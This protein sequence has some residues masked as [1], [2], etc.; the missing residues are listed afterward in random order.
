MNRRE[1]DAETYDRI[2][3]VQVAWAKPVLERLPLRGDETV[4]DAGCGSGRVTR[5]LLERLP[6]GRVIAVDADES[7]LAHAREARAGERAT[8]LAADLADLEL[9]HSVDAVFSNAVFHWVPDHDRLFQ[10]MHAALR[11]GGQLIAQCGG[12]GNLEDFLSLVDVVAAE[13]PYS[14]YLQNFRRIWCFAGA[15]ETEGRLRRAGFR[16]A[17]AWLEPSEVVREDPAEFLRTVV[18]GVHLP[19]L[20]EELRDPFVEAV[21]ARCEQPLRLLYIRLNIDARR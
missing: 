15:E 2:S 5:M 6:A 20:P 17:R 10:R 18:L 16:E 7:M 4:L 12:E 19:W 9:E 14:E 11:P 13:P 3:D 1:W 21:L 8:V